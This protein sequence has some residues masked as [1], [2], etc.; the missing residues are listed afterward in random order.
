MNKAFFIRGMKEIV[1][2]IRE[3]NA[4]PMLGGVYPNNWYNSQHY[5]I[6]KETHIEILT[7]GVPVFDF[8]RLISL[9]SCMWTF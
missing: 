5:E 9:F 3:L 4:K 6:L 8:L 1:E 2:K 7:W